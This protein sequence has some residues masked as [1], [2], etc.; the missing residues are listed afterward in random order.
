MSTGET[1]SFV[2]SETLHADCLGNYSKTSPN[3][4]DECYTATNVTQVS[5]FLL[6]FLSPFSR[7]VS[8]RKFSSK[9]KFNRYSFI[10]LFRNEIVSC[11]IELRFVQIVQ[12]L[13]FVFEES[14]NWCFKRCFRF[15]I[16][17]LLSDFSFHLHYHE[18]DT[19]FLLLSVWSFDQSQ[20]STEGKKVHGFARIPSQSW[21]VPMK[22][23]STR[24]ANIW[25]KPEQLLESA[26]D[27]G[28]KRKNVRDFIINIPI[29]PLPNK[30]Q[31]ESQTVSGHFN[32]IRT[33]LFEQSEISTGRKK[34]FNTILF[35]NSNLPSFQSS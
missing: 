29:F 30:V 32:K 19:N 28:G 7:I 10:L 4:L 8:S 34:I 16:E 17:I 31:P 20:I 27:T 12:K 3:C 11:K 35:K 2:D 15:L 25:I 9:M 6:S 5:P 23:K 13:S 18:F 33:K 26:A 21:L 22:F 14:G 1:I 24:C